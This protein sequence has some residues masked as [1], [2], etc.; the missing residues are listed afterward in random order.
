MTFYQVLTLASIVEQEAIVD[1]ERPLIAG[2]YQ[3]RLDGKN[4]HDGLLQADPTVIYA[5]DTVDLDELAVRRVA[6]VLLLGRC[7][8]AGSPRSSCP[9]ELARLPDLPRAGLPPGPDRHAQPRLDRRG[10]RARTPKTGYLYFVAKNDG[11]QAHAFAKTLAEHEAN[12][13]KYGY[14]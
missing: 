12:L 14:R 7:P 11:A 5:N 2:V 1:E 8:R 9:T 6:A 3:N 4:G 13:R 10:A